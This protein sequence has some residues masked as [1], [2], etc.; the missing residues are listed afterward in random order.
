M[1]TVFLD[2]GEFCEKCAEAIQSE[3]YVSKQS[4]S[5]NRPEPEKL[6]S[7]PDQPPTAQ[8]K[9]HDKDRVYIWLGIGTSA[10]MMCASMAIYAFPNLLEDPA[11]LAARAEEQRVED[12]R[13]V[14][15]EITYA[16]QA[17]SGS[18]ESMTCASSAGPNQ[19]RRIGDVVRVD[20]PNPSAYGLSE[21]YVTNQSHQV[22]LVD[23][24]S[25]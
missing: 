20:H 16:L 6:R 23:G 21:I 25:S 4:D 13:L 10:A 17:G 14:F 2:Q 9:Q 3:A 18:V 8:E 12:C 5:L 7:E 19:V 11:V 22:F 1:C 24:E 15:E